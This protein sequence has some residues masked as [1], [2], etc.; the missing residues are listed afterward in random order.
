MGYDIEKGDRLYI[1]WGGGYICI[2]T[3][4]AGPCRVPC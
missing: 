1:G 4:V 2:C 3:A